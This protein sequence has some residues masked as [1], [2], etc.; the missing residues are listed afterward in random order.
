MLKGVVCGRVHADLN[1]NPKNCLFEDVS[2]PVGLGFAPNLTCQVTN[3]ALDRSTFWLI[4]RAGKDGKPAWPVPTSDCL[5]NEGTQMRPQIVPEK[6]PVVVCVRDPVGLDVLE[7]S[8][9]EIRKRQ[10][11]SACCL[12]DSDPSSRVLDTAKDM[13]GY[14]GVTWLDSTEHRQF[15]VSAAVARLSDSHRGIS[16]TT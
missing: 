9:H 5:D 10:G 3:F 7:D 14:S 16:T 2:V 4:R 11:R 12:Q 13:A 6:K 8:L 15:R 1:S